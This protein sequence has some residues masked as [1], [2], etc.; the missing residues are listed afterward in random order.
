MRPPANPVTDPFGERI[1]QRH[2]RNLYL[3]GALF[4]FESNSSRLLRL[5]DQAFGGLPRHRLG[6]AVPRLRIRLQ[7]APGRAG[8]SPDPRTPPVLQTWSGPGFLCGVM[9]GSNMAIIAPAQRAALVVISRQLLA[10]RYYARYELIEFAVYVLAERVQGLMPLHAAAVG[11]RGRGVLLMG[12]SGAG[13]STLALHC[14]LHGLAMVSEDGVFVAA[15]SLL[16]TGVASFLHLHRSGLSLLHAS[17]RA[18]L[19]RQSNIIRRRSGARKLE[20]D[21]R[22]TSYR[23]APTPLALQA[24]VFLSKRRAGDR[25]LLQ[26][27][28]ARELARRLASHQSYA[29]SLPGWRRLVT[30]LRGVRAFELRRGSHPRAAVAALRGLLAVPA[31]AVRCA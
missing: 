30:R 23:L 27:L 25:Q 29:A 22:R 9:D 18:L 16:A 13:K 3:L 11:D 7:V 15:D 12:D 5:V 6:R 8:N 21:L 20:V 10:Q 24:V 19:S 26:P 28:A 17:D 14:L 4:R 2:H 1:K 31:R